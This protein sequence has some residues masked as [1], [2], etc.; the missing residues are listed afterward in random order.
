MEECLD[1]LEREPGL[2]GEPKD[3]DSMDHVGIE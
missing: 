1:F 2:L 3:I